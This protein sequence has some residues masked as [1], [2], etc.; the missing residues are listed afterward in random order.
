LATRRVSKKETEELKKKDGVFP[1]LVAELVAQDRLGLGCLNPG[2]GCTVRAADELH[3]RVLLVLPKNAVSFNSPYVRPE[4]VLVT[5][6]FLDQNGSK[7]RRISART[8][9][10]IASQTVQVRDVWKGQYVAS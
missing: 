2:Q 6:S 8:A 7:K 1:H 9:S 5:R 4:P 3:R 10:S